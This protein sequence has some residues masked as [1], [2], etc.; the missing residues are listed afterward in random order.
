MPQ[1]KLTSLVVQRLLSREYLTGRLPRL[2]EWQARAPQREL[3][4]RVR[5]I[6]VQAGSL[7][8]NANEEQVRGEIINKV[9]AI[10]N[11]HYLA[12]EKLS[13]G[14]TPDYVLFADAL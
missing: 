1:P 13:T 5:E 6:F 12:G 4:D 11:P 9:L 8:D 10:I 7:V 14:S 3:F 2:A